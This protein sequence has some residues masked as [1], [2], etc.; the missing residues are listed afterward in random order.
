M[1]KE[2]IKLRIP[3]ESF[4]GRQLTR[5][6]ARI[7]NCLV[8]NDYVYQDVVR[9][10]PETGN[11]T[12]LLERVNTPVSACYY[13]GEDEE[14]ARGFG[15]RVY[16]AFCQYFEKQHKIGVEGM[17]PGMA[18]LSV[19]KTMSVEQLGQLVRAAPVPLILTLYAD[20]DPENF[21]IDKLPPPPENDT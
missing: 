15:A 14:Q 21:D 10:D 11:V 6:T 16:A 19:P 4:W 1:N 5:D 13:V 3:G 18:R 17:S 2:Y 8:S 20:T 9:F 12:E 7:D